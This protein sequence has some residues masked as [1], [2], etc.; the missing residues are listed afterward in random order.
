LRVELAFG[1]GADLDLYVTDPALETVYF[2][3]TP[4]RL[5]GLEAD[6]R[7]GSAGPRIEVVRFPAA[8][9]GR[10]R[11]GVDFPERCGTRGDEGG[12]RL[13]VRGPGVAREIEGRVAFGRFESRVL[14]FELAA[15]P[16]RDAECGASPRG[17][18]RALPGA[19]PIKHAA[20]TAD[21][22]PG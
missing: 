11:V 2:A 7:C 4:T 8:P 12:F 1:E 21:E 10:Y 3:N 15:P 9:A 13:R 16:P 14:E 6:L 17:C 19:G 5:G 18:G 20:G 22:P